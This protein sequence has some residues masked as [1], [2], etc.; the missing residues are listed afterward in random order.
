M[1]FLF[2]SLPAYGHIYPMMPLAYAVQEAGHDVVFSTAGDFVPRLRALGFETYTAGFTVEEART[3]RFGADPPST[4]RNGATDWNVIGDLFDECATATARDLLPQ[5]SA[6]A[7]DLMVYE[8]LDVGAAVVAASTGTPAVCQAILRGLPSAIHERLYGARPDALL[9]QL[10]GG[11]SLD[12][13]RTGPVLD[14]YPPSLQSTSVLANPMR[15]GM[16]PVPWSEPWAQVP[17]W[18][19]RS[20][21]PLVYVTFGTVRGYPESF[22]VVVEGLADLDV[23]VLVA[24]AGHHDGELDALPGRVHIEP[25]VHQAE[26]L[27]HLDV[28]IHHGG[29]GTTTGA[30]TGAIPQLV[31]PQGADQFINA[32]VVSSSGSGIVLKNS[33]A[34]LVAASVRALLDDP[35]YRR[36]ARPIR[37]EITSMPRPSDVVTR[38]VASAHRFA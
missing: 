4:V 24:T 19:G 27:G 16:R 9:S 11:A 29:C 33:S 20:S 18:I 34:D 22:R 26:L 36:A 5:M 17:S 30:W 1:K 12:I 38:L 21:R 25:F 15:I 3:S 14:T 32:D 31:I 13:A 28:M 37:D 2:R 8:Q 10:G 35:A 7:P 6:S 23:D